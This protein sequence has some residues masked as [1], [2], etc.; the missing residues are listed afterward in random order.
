[1]PS[2]LESDVTAPKPKR[3]VWFYVLAALLLAVGAA[4]AAPLIYLSNAGGMKGVLEA[5]LGKALGGVPVSVGD[6]GYELSMPSMHVTLAA[7][8]VSFTLLD[9]QIDLPEANAMFSL[10][11][12]WRLA[13]YEVSLAGLDLDVTLDGD[14]ASSPIGLLAAAVSA[15]GARDGT[16]IERS[17]N[18]R[19]EDARLTLRSR[20]RM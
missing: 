2:E 3:R 20:G 18:L 9:T 14:V 17:R 10:D 11:G 16:I 1:M 4:I 7:F 15:P 8:D 5:Q 6:V 13:P 19:I 12:L